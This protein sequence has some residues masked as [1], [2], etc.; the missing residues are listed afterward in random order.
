MPAKV[1]NKGF[2][3]LSEINVT[4]FVDV[5]L[6]LLV[7]FMVT[8]PMMAQGIKVDLPEAAAKELQLDEKQII[9]TV[10]ADGSIFLDKYKMDLAGLGKKL[11]AIYKDRRSREIFLRADKEVRYGYVVK[12]MAEVKKAGLEKL[13]MITESPRGP[14]KTE[15][16]G[17]S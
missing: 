13:G 8:A 9:L 5:M 12:V 14:S 11:E 3:T 15:G 16:P 2:T 4:P 1:G 6:V 7:I 17:E 10:K